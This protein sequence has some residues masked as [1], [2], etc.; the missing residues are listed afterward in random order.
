MDRI[1]DL[2]DEVLDL[3]ML[4][5][6]LRDRVRASVVSQRWSEIC[7]SPSEMRLDWGNCLVTGNKD[8]DDEDNHDE[9][10]PF[11]RE[12]FVNNVNRFLSSFRGSHVNRFDLRFCL[13]GSSKNDMDGWIRFA[14]RR[15]VQSMS[16]ISFCYNGV[17]FRNLYGNDP[18]RSFEDI[19]YVIDAELFDTPRCNLKSLLLG[20]CNIG[21]D[22]AKHLRGLKT[23]NLAYS[24]LA[25]YDMQTLF[26]GLPNLLELIFSRCNLPVELS[27]SCL[28][29]LRTFTLKHCSGVQHIYLFHVNLSCFQL[30]TERV[31]KCD[32]VRAPNLVSLGCS[33]T[34]MTLPYFFNH[35]PTHAP[36]LTKLHVICHGELDDCIPRNLKVFSRVMQLEW[37][38]KP[39]SRL[40][41]AK[42]INILKAFP[43][44]RVLLVVTSNAKNLEENDQLMDVSY[45][46]ED[47]SVV[48]MGKF[49][50]TS[51]QI[52]F[53]AYLLKHATKLKRLIIRGQKT[54]GEA[55]RQDFLSKIEGFDK[56]VKVIVSSMA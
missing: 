11:Y 7:L 36:M 44:L 47:L 49:L 27:L 41:I 52:S 16:F 55:A 6:S 13:T 2:P 34:R 21:P 31:V 37:Y 24:F 43:L 10:C 14:V 54:W 32:L 5:I 18:D 3:I 51:A 15:G 39:N 12:V 26:S 33:A 1:S 30:F 46:P 50:G 9:F 22:F 45:K 20:G 56:D 17:D 8:S 29:S 42:M 35:I 23:L 53:V 40:G 48:I 19:Q 4:K 38:F 25:H 28:P